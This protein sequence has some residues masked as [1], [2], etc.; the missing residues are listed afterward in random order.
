MQRPVI[1]RRDTMGCGDTYHVEPRAYYEAAVSEQLVTSTL[2]CMHGRS[3]G[4]V[5]VVG[6]DAYP[7]TITFRRA[8]HRALAFANRL[9]P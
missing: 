9:S 1:R 3:P 5:M 6:L 7:E 4:A 2:V 8:E